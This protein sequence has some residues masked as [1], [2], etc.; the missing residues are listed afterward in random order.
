[1][2]S[3]NAGNLFVAD[4]NNHRIRKI[5]TSGIITTIAGK[6]GAGYSGD[7]M[8]A[9]NTTLYSPSGLAFDAYN[10]LFIA[11]TMNNRV[12]RVDTTGYVMTVAGTN[13]AGSTGDGGLATIAKLNTDRSV[14]FDALGNLYIADTSN[15]RIRKMN[16]NGVIATV[17]G[18]GTANFSGDGGNAT[19]ASLNYPCGVT[20]DSNGNLFIADTRNNRIRKVG[21]NGIITTVAGK[22]P[23]YPSSGTYSGDG[24]AATNAYINNPRGVTIDPV[25][26]LFIAL[27]RVI[28][29]FGKV[30]ANGLISTV[31][32]QIWGWFLR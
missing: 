27:M 9:T 5:D 14:A 15:S 11:D 8:A 30:D 7:G 13:T 21:A 12:R 6:S 26:N 10:N 20:I 22:G 29:G 3:D 23:S 24:G 25:G 17:A 1:M 4:S 16:T 2:T 19:N 28:I 31:A 18:N 32:G